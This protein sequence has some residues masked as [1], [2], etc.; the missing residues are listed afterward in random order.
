MAIYGRN[1]AAGACDVGVGFA[2]QTEGGH[3]CVLCWSFLRG[4]EATPYRSVCMSTSNIQ[5]EGVSAFS[6]APAR[7]EIT[8]M[9]G[10]DGL[11]QPKLWASGPPGEE[12]GEGA[13]G[14]LDS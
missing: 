7:Q 9:P 1:K 5:P 10:D 13:F 8:N 11:G 3:R 14:L 12:D 4:V 6:Q 2:S